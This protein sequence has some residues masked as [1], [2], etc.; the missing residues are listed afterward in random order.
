MEVNKMKESLRSHLE[1]LFENAPKTR[2]AFELKEELYTNSV[3]RYDD[4]VKS[5]ISPE[6]AYKNVVNSIGN[7]SDLFRGLEEMSQEEIRKED[8][9]IKKLA[10]IKTAAI[11]LYFLS[12]VVFL[13]FGMVRNFYFSR[14]DSTA[15][16]LIVMLLIDIIPTC[17]LVYVS[18]AYPKY[19]M[20]DNTVVEEF[21][22][23]KSESQKIRAIKGSIY[24]IIWT[25]SIILYFAVSFATMAWYISWVI[26]L[27]AF[28]ATAVAKLVIQLR[29]M[30]E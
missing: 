2:K 10:L 8:E 19:R 16:G 3:E 25:V 28:C 22:A 4:L 17:M 7:V 20:S 15:L 14:I 1:L 12:V 26:F 11:G 24:T 5:G 21:K 29:E 9:K 27:I 13:W 6:D 30:K 18:S 23:W